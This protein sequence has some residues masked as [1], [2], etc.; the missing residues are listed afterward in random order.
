MALSMMDSAV[1]F[2]AQLGEA[3]RLPG[4]GLGHFAKQGK[5]AYL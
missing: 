3:R 5:T 4:F 2:M 1:I